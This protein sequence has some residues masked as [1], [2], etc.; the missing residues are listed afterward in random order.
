MEGLFIPIIFFLVVGAI[1]ITWIYYRSRERTMLIEK[2]LSLDEIKAL[3]YKKRDPYLMLK[4][5]IVIL[6]FGIGLGVGI[7]LQNW[8]DED[9][10]VPLIMIS[11]TG[12]GF[13]V[14]HT[15]TN[16]NNAGD[17]E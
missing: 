16:K 4:F 7:L 15:V 3:Y 11:M 8:T 13:I 2:G 5:G 10:W 17:Q 9:A 12:D 14:A 6:F 1:M